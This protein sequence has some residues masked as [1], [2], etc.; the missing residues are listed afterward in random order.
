M[1]NNH[2][3]LGVDPSGAVCQLRPHQPAA[4]PALL[5]GDRVGLVVHAAEVGGVDGV[6]VRHS[7]V[8]GALP[9][10]GAEVGEA[11]EGAPGSPEEKMDPGAGSGD[12]RTGIRLI[13]NALSARHSL[14]GVEQSRGYRQKSTL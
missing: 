14:R 1:G 8:F 9:Q 6:S 10:L 4:G 12:F 11:L 2:H 3:P 7:R 13:S 5:H